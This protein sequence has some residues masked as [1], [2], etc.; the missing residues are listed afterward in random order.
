ML[1]SITLTRKFGAQM[2]PYPRLIWRALERKQQSPNSSQQ[3]WDADIQAVAEPVNGS[4]ATP[5]GVK[6]ADKGDPRTS[7]QHVKQSVSIPW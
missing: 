4:C 1:S 5:D 7:D 2:A 6:S 3:Y